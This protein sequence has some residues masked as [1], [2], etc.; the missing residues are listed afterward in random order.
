MRRNWLL[1]FIILTLVVGGAVAKGEAD[2]QPRRIGLWNK[3][4]PLGDGTFQEAEAWITVHRP[5]KPNGAAVVICPGGG[6]AGLVT[7]I[8]VLPASK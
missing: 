5:E 4:A 6:Y 7:E 1:H 3:R 2:A 8:K